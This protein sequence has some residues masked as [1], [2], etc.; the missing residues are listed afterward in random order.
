MRAFGL[1]V[2]HVTHCFNAMRPFHHRD[3]GC[4]GAALN[5]PEVSVELIADGVHVHPAAMA[6]L[7]RLKG[8]DKTVLV[9]DGI[10][11]AG[12]G[13]GSFELGSARVEVK[14]GVARL[15]DGTLAGSATPLDAMVR[16]AVAL[17]H[18]N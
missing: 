18:M 13:D 11:L 2:R 14:D 6:M 8:V 4:V 10:S 16:N 3:P 15:H 9:S 5:S 12:L 17:L 1:G 7:L